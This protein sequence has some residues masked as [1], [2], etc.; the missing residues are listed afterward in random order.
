MGRAD[1]K[2]R[3]LT[4]T[5]ELLRRQGYAG[6]GLKQVTAEASAPWGSMYHFFPHGKEQLAI[7]AVH[8]A[9]ELYGVPMAAAFA[10]AKD[11]IKAVR[12]LFVNEV[13]V[14][15]GSDYR[16]G[17]PITNTAGDVASTVEPVREA[18]SRGFAHWQAIIA[19]GFVDGG[20]SKPQAATC[21]A[22]VLSSLEGAILLSRTH[23]S[24]EP[25][26][27]TGQMVELALKAIMARSANGQ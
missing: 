5:S 3:F 8:Y 12:M 6:T 13:Q 11:P 16:D 4:A 15:E 23:K 21:A 1:T 18:C 7:E 24:P 25:L 20:L 17:C 22:F 14:L 19:A 9:S 26:R 10:R 2:Q 27:A